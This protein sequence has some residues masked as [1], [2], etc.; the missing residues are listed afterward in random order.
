MRIPKVH[1]YRISKVKDKK[2]KIDY[3]TIQVTLKPSEYIDDLGMFEDEK[4]LHK[5]V[6]RTK[7]YIRKSYEYTKFI[8]F[9]KKYRGMYCCGIHSNITIWDKFSVEI[10]HTPLTME[11]IIYI[12]INKRMKREESLKQSAIA[13]EVMQLHYLGLVGLYPLCD[14][15]HTYVH[16]DNNDLFIPFDA[17]YGDPESFFDIYQ[18]FITTTMKVKFKNLQELNKGYSFIQN[19]VPEALIRKYI[20]VQDSANNTRVSTK[21][22]QSFIQALED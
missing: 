21:K 1:E 14:A 16:S 12:V 11:D 22:L 3:E 17:I 10:H 19:E 8:E 6:V 13:K 15:C 4:E 18:D 5:F 2:E 9:L 7:Y 20:L